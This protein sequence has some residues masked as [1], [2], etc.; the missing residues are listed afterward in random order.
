M[1]QHFSSEVTKS[2]GI[3]NFELQGK[4]ARIEVQ[5]TRFKDQGKTFDL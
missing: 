1:L 4:G 2:K 5:G 3:A